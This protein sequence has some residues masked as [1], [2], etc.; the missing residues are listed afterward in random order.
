M[1]RF[2]VGD[3]LRVKIRAGWYSRSPA[4]T[5]DAVVVFYLPKGEG[6]SREQGDLYYGFNPKRPWY[7]VPALRNH[8]KY[9]RVFLRKESGS[10]FSAALAEEDDRNPV[11]Y[12]LLGR[13]NPTTCEVIGCEVCG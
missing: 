7:S 4:K 1:P 6:I 3:Q 10:Y 2:S 5:F 13:H 11:R 9:D 8:P 12:E